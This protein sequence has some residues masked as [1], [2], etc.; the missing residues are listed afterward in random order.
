MPGYPWASGALA[1]IH[2]QLG[3]T[4]AA[5]KHLNTFVEL[6]PDVARNARAEWSKWIV[7]GEFVEH[8]VDG[9]RKAGLEVE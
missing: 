7:S 9:L 4:E 5:R 3:Q 8:L 2:A 1:A 6:A